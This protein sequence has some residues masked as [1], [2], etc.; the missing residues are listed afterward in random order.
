MCREVSP[1]QVIPQRSWTCTA[2][3]VGANVSW[4]SQLETFGSSLKS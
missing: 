1:A 2:L 3:A 4:H